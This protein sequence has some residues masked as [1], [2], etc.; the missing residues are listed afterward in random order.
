LQWN[1]MLYVTCD[2]WGVN[3]ITDTLKVL[4]TYDFL[5]QSTITYVWANVDNRVLESSLF[6]MNMVLL[7]LHYK[8][9]YS[10][11]L[12]EIVSFLFCHPVTSC[13]VNAA[14]ALFFHWPI[15]LNKYLPVIFYLH[16]LK[17]SH[18]VHLCSYSAID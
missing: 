13:R 7:M 2:R 4:I 1:K 5:S 11:S 18:L 6:V 3:H 15:F 8:Y 16:K 14:L 9:Y 12:P 17:L 10:S